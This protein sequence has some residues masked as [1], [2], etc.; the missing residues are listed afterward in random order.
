MNVSGSN[1]HSVGLLRGALRPEADIG[2]VRVLMRQRGELVQSASQH[3][4]HMHKS[5]TQMNL[6]IHHVI[7]DITGLTGSATVDAILDGQSDPTE[8][9]KLRDARISADEEII[10][11]IAGGQL[12]GG[13]PAY[14]QT[15]A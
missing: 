5:L 7:S 9:A 8:L 15:I 4:Q 14:A 3:V 6:Q 1:T 2:A 13:A 10:L 12:E 11:Q